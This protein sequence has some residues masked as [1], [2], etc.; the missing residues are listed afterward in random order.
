[1]GAWQQV[2]RGN[3]QQIGYIPQTKQ[4]DTILGFMLLY[5][6]KLPLCTVGSHLSYS[7]SVIRIFVY[8][9]FW[10]ALNGNVLLYVSTNS[11]VSLFRTFQLSEHPLLYMW[12]SRIEIGYYSIAYFER[13]TEFD[14]L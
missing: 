11:I 1:M 5:L 12:Q 10:C 2:A 9:I 6:G 4:H 7:T 13:I 8:P 3:I 14:A